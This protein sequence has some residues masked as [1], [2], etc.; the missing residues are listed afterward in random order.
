MTTQPNSQLGYEL[1]KIVDEYHKSL[2][3][4]GQDWDFTN[5][6]ANLEYI[7]MSLAQTMT[8]NGGIG[9]AANQ[10]RLPWNIFVMG[11]GQEIECIINPVIVTREGEQVEIEGC[12]S[13]PGLF[14]KIKR[15]AKIVVKY[16]SIKGA[17]KEQTF[18]GLTA[19]IFQHEFDH[20]QGINFKKL[21]S[22]I[23][24]QRAKE[25]VALTLR[26]MKAMFEERKKS[27]LAEQAKNIQQ[28]VERA[29]GGIPKVA[30]GT[31]LKFSTGVPANT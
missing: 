27:V 7:A 15:A 22:P 4:P 16:T 28:S 3:I 31:I 5:P 6:T 8:Q 19:R 17:T 24:L 13:A 23:K 9:L 25:K 29:K 20:L 12:L 11:T 2:T 10:V 26:R 1:Y 30:P 21:V 18:E 14:L